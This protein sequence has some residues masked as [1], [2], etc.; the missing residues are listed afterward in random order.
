MHQ[1]G[2]YYQADA[3]N[4]VQSYGFNALQLS[5]PASG[6]T[7]TAHFAGVKGDA[8]YNNAYDD[9]AGWRWG[10]VGIKSDGTAVYG[11]MSRQDEGSISF[12][13]S[14]PLYKLYFVVSGAPKEHFHHIW[15]NDNSN[16]EQY[17]WKVK[18]VNTNI[19]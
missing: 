1:A 7:V 13:V 12:A 11:D 17:P 15:D 4:C 3:S 14:E 6:T 9:I 5:A 16:D 2:D 10:F 19:K 8:A 18:L